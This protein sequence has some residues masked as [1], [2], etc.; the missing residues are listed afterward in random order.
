MSQ[1]LIISG[2][3]GFLGKQLQD[4]FSKNFDIYLL[5]HDIESASGKLHIA[6]G[7]CK[8]SE[9]N[10]DEIAHL[11][12]GSEVVINLSGASIGVKRWTENHKR[13]ILESRIKATSIIVEA[14]ERAVMKP[15]LLI[16]AS[17]VGYY[18]D[19]KD[20][21]LN[22]EAQNGDGFLA[23]VCKQWEEQAI[24]AEQL[25]R[26]VRLRTGL[27]LDKEEGVLP[28]FLLPYKFF[29]GGRIG[30]GNQWISW[31]HIKDYLRLI[32][33]IINNEQIVGAVNA[34]SPNPILM[35][36]FVRILSKCLKRPNIFSI[37]ELIL[38]IILG[39]SSELLLQSQRA[40]PEKILTAGFE[41]EFPEI[42]SAF[43]SL[44]N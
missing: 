7:L 24:Q 42:E 28:R 25:L 14:I 30:S 31:I 16:S 2:G 27:V 22:E 19:G 23:E 29:V 6:K 36:D 41:F 37:P 1:K 18:G 39:E 5:T 13:I 17:G 33:F 43:E 44:L 26:V 38:K 34:V 40:I 32:E 8:L 12:D 3:T 15:E 10:I 4:Y 20:F 11:M 9:S 35:R 21:I